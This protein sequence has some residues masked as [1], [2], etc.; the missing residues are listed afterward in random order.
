MIDENNISLF[1]GNN[2]HL[3][4]YPINRNM[5]LNLVCI[6]RNKDYDPDNLRTLIEQKFLHKTQNSS[7]FLKAI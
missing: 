5:E 7:I 3:V 4:F 6:I 1:M 2:C